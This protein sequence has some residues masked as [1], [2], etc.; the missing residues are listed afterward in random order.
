MDHL[1]LALAEACGA[2]VRP[3]PPLADAAA[4][5]DDGRGQY[6]AGVL[7]DL[8]VA[9]GGAGWR[10]GVSGWDLFEDGLEFVLG[11]AT[12]G[13]CCAVIA[14]PRLRE[15]ADAALLFRRALTEAVHELGHVA[16]LPHCP[17]PTCVMSVSRTVADVDAKG[18]DFCPDCRAGGAPAAG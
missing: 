6:G 15:G 3:G 5:R 4:A 10:L 7:V 18:L 12:L 16:G 9:R 2:E 17:R 8:L 11:Q 13:G 1:R 14:L